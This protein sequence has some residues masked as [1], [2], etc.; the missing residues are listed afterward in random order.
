MIKLSNKHTREAATRRD[1][2]TSKTK[3]VVPARNWVDTLKTQA[4]IAAK[5]RRMFG[6]AFSGRRDYGALD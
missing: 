1:T 6:Q 5:N 4:C 2:H 3:F